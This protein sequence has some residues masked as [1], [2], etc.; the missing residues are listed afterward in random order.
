MS[1][2]DPRIADEAIKFINGNRNDDYGAPKDALRQVAQFWSAYLSKAITASDVAKMMLLLK[3]ARSMNDY[4]RDTYIDGVAYLLIAE[5]LDN[6]N[7]N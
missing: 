3:L 4:K 5:D 6:G 7:P 2:V 1:F